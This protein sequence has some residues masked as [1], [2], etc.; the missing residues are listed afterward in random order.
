MPDLI[1]EPAQLAKQLDDNNLLIVDLCQEKNWLQHH[2][3]G[4]VHV[5]PAELVSGMKPATG[6][7]PDKQRLEALFSRLGYE[8]GKHLVAYDDEGG[9]WAGRFIWTLDVIGHA[10][11]SLLNGGL[12]AWAN[13]GFPMTAEVI[14]PAP[15]KVNITLSDA[16]VAEKE[17]LLA[18]IG[19]D[20]TIIWDAR[21]PEEWA[22][23]KVAAAR[24]GHIPG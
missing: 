12:I 8:P 21:A 15:T 5:H 14:E 19:R 1:I 11:S 13:E 3:P 10:M 7:L 16:V 2:L 22:G 20:D 18:A 23:A 17:D 9:G 24:G 4:A 6:K